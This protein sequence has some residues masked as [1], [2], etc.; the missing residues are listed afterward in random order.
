MA[1]QYN[2][3]E[4]LALQKL[5]Y[6]KA[7]K[8]GHV[9]IED[10]EGRLKRWSSDIF[11]QRPEWDR[12]KEEYYRAAGKFLY[13]YNFKDQEEKLMWELHSNGLSLPNIVKELKARGRKAYRCKVQRIIQ[14]LAR[15]M[16]AGCLK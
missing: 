7:A 10:K 6:A 9:E 16:V 13:D 2:S 1:N 3:K 11:G 12:S 14:S 4:F 15:K 8:A 5:W